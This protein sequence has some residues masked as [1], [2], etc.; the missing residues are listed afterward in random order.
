MD[1]FLELFISTAYAAGKLPKSK[2]M[3]LH[4]IIPFTLAMVPVFIVILIKL[5]PSLEKR[6]GTTEKENQSAD[7]A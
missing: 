1:K 7:Q 5:K 3:P 6:F 2:G 4:I